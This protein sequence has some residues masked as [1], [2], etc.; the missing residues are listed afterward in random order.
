MSQDIS[1]VPQLQNTDPYQHTTNSTYKEQM[2]TNLKKNLDCIIGKLYVISR[3]KC[4]LERM[5]GKG[6][7]A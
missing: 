6:S 3:K 1:T 7:Y 4:N 5:V 2:L